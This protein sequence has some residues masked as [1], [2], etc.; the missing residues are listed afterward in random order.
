MSQP[1]EL[2]LG[3]GQGCCLAPLLFN[4]I[5]GAVIE[6]WQQVSGCRL[7]WRTRLDGVLRIQA[8]LD[9]YAWA[10]AN[11]RG[12]EVWIYSAVAQKRGPQC[13]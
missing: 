3:I 8:Q 9:K 10:D 1:F 5:L 2:E 4:E 7:E 12:M 13:V 11:A 6:M